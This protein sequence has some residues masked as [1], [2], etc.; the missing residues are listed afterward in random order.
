VKPA[1]HNKQ[2]NQQGMQFSI[3][4]VAVLAPGRLDGRPRPDARGCS[5]FPPPAPCCVPCPLGFHTVRMTRP[6]HAARPHTGPSAPHCFSREL[7]LSWR[8]GGK[9]RR[10]G[11][12]EERAR[13]AARGRREVGA[14][15]LPQLAG[16]CP[17]AIGAIAT[18]AT[19]A[20]FLKHP[21]ETFATIPEN[22]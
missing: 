18:C 19:P 10:V 9:G 12:R 3:W 16:R 13:R 22:I 2:V 7:E 17:P 5:A 8:D 6:S 15:A 4:S 14:E 11:R 20:L 21:D 1:R